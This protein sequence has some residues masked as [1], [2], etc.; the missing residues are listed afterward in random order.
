MGGSS[1][2]AVERDQL[3]I[4]RVEFIT[5]IVSESTVGKASTGVQLK[6]R[7][8]SRIPTREG[9]RLRHHYN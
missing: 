1:L 3:E 2:H 6:D 4:A 7:P 8:E 5:D 9:G